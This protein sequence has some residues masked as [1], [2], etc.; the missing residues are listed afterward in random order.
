MR[1]RS[2]AIEARPQTQKYLS[3]RKHEAHQWKNVPRHQIQLHDN[4]KINHSK[5]AARTRD[6]KNLIGVGQVVIVRGTGQ[7]KGGKRLH[8]HAK[9]QEKVAI[10]NLVQ[11]G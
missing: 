4:K 3:R 8:R 11:N 10:H 2:G 1:T 9:E 5:L 7:H 6:N